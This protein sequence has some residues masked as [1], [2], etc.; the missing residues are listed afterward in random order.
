MD[1]LKRIMGYAWR[2]KWRLI[3]AT[4]F[5]LLVITLNMVTPYLSKILVDDVIR[6]GRRSLLLPILLA[7]LGCSVFKGILLYIRSYLYED[8]S[9]KCLYDLRNAMYTHLQ[10]LSFSFYDDNRI[11]ELMSRMTG[12]IEGIRM[13]L[14]GGLPILLE[15]AIYFIGTCVML[16]SLNVELALVT[17]LILPFI[18]W[19]AFR[20]HKEIGPA[21]SEIREQQASLS[22]AA[23]E[24]IAGVR[25]VRAFARESYEIEKFKKENRLN[26]EKNIKASFIWSKYFPLIEFLSG[27]CLVALVG[28]GGWMVAAGRISL[29]TVVAFN[30]YLWMLI[31]PVR[32]LG[33]IVNVMSQAITAGKRVF[34]V[35]DTGSSIKEKEN[36]YCPSEFRGDVVFENVSFCYKEQPVLFN[37]NINAPAGKTIGIMGATGAGKTSIINL[38]ARFY[39]VTAGRVLVDGVDVRDW[40]LSALRSQIGIVMQD[41]FLF[42]DTVEGNILY[43]N[44][45]ATREQVIEAAKIAGAHDFIMEMPQGYDTIIGERG[46][47]LS[48]GQKQRIAIA[49]AIIKNPKILIMDDCTSAVDMET[50]YQIQQALKKIMK[51]RTTFIIAHRISSVRNADEIIFLENGKIVERGTH[52]ELLA[53]KGRYYELYRQQYKDFEEFQLKRQVM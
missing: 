23:Q 21:Y 2:Y 51:G 19:T 35:L 5:L 22:T 34:N 39:D 42:S 16:F 3:A 44:P 29:G 38:I 45:N 33:W 52:E 43:G 7:L 36:A 26:M 25:V 17:L 30:G 11:G 53:K 49:R 10:E 1:I 40:K 20:L 50:E 41:V 28:Y 46:V 15:N 37:I 4:V 14:V 27:F 32:M 6:G 47:G 12:D 48:G 24:N 31:S 8:M 13:F 18:G 9:Q